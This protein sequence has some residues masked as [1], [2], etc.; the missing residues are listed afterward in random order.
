MQIVPWV[1]HE[2]KMP[3]ANTD[4]PSSFKSCL[5]MC[6]SFKDAD[7]TFWWL[8]SNELER[9]WKVAVVV[10][11]KVISRCLSGGTEE[12]HDRPQ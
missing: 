4:F 3:T 5:F 11:F 12:N 7:D 8:L 10:W 1:T 6:C 9:M 2:K